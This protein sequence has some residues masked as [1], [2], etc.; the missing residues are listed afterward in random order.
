MSA[1]D[2]QNTHPIEVA[3][4]TTAAGSVRSTRHTGGWSHGEERGGRFDIASRG[5]R[6]EGVDWDARRVIT[7]RGTHDADGD[8]TAA[9]GR[10]IRS[11]EYDAAR[12]AGQ[13]QC[14]A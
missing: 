7:G 13:R 1:C 3:A 2:Q 14:R 8:I 11:G 6:H 10:N 4:A 12:R 9:I 5:T